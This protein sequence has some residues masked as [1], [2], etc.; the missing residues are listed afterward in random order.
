MQEVVRQCAVSGVLCDNVFRNEAGELVRVLSPYLNLDRSMARGVDFEIDYSR[1]VNFFASQD[2]SLSIR[3]LGGRL[4]ERTSTVVGGTPAEFA[5]TR[6]YPDMSAN[7]T[8]T[9]RVNKWTVQLQE[10]Y[11]DEVNL[12]RLWTEGIDVDDNTISSRAW[13]N[14]VLGYGGEMRERGSWRITLNVQNLFDKDPPII[15]ASGDT[16]F[17]AQATDPLYDEF[18][19]RYQLGFNMDF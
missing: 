15:A 10:R 2:E 14:L 18:G 7:A 3:V 13:T 4:L 6:G 11:L 16:R 5:G 9:Y 19:R 1:D 17:G 8:L 12:N